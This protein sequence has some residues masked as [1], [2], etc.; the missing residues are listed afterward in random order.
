METSAAFVHWRVLSEEPERVLDDLARYTE[1]N[2]LLLSNVLIPDF[3]DPNPRSTPLLLPDADG[4]DGLPVTAAPDAFETVVRFAELA[5]SKGFRTVCHTMPSMAFTRDLAEFDTVTVRGKRS[6]DSKKTGMIWGC[7]NNPMTI[8]YGEEL[9]G[10]SAQF[11]SFADMLELN[12]VE[13]RLWPRG[14]VDE[15]MVCFCDHCRKRAEDTGLDFEGMKRAATSFCEAFISGRLLPDRTTSFRGLMDSLKETPLLTAW[16]RFRMTS[17]SDFIRR[18]TTA[19]RTSAEKSNPNLK[20]G[21][22]FFLPSAANLVGTDFVSLY[23]LFDWVSPKFPDYVPGTILPLISDEL[24]SNSGDGTSAGFMRAL[25]TVL[26]LGEGPASYEPIQPPVEDLRYSNAFDPSII[27]RQS[28]YLEALFG[29]VKIYPWIWIYN[30]D[31]D[32]FRWKVEAVKACGFDG[33]F[34]WNWEVDLSAERLKMSAG[35]FQ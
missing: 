31:L 22:D 2:T 7:P 16:S 32:L 1:I 12:H 13:F 4:F 11:W 9:A 17:M 34:V 15:L 3:L 35:C 26:D 21:M 28:V 25:R 6:D 18:V 23:P 30:R 24:A 14:G 29:K 19:A 8:Q 10:R 33:Y 5:E 27:Q 20:I